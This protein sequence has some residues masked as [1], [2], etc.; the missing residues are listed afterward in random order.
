M[1]IRTDPL[2]PLLPFAS[3]SSSPLRIATWNCA[4]V[5]AGLAG[6]FTGLPV[7]PERFVV[8]PIARALAGFDLV[9]IQEAF[10]PIA[11]TFVEALGRALGMYCWLERSGES[12]TR[13]LPYGSGLAVLARRPIQVEFAPFHATPSGFD[14]WSNKGI[15]S[16]TV[17]VADRSGAEHAHRIHVVH[18][19]MQS[20]DPPLSPEVFRAIRA[21]Q[22]RELLTTLD[23]Q[24]R[25][26][27]LAARLVLGDFNI[28]AND[29][30]Y[31]SMLTP[32]M[33]ARRLVDAVTDDTLVTF[34]PTQNPMAAKYR[35]YER[36]V[37]VDHLWIGDGLQ[38]ALATHAPPR[39]I[40]H[41]AISLDARGRP[42][43]ASDHYGLALDLI[44]SPTRR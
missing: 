16:L 19:H 40:L 18:T 4:G 3:L 44:L 30:E 25:E 41:A 9:C 42:L 24:A 35:P 13:R 29:D 39:L 37:R 28:R 5:P 14:G 11:V 34:S 7:R 17:D 12:P 1:H 21:A 2:W 38:T 15:S 22:L 33:H 43:F 20:D 27:P 10:V 26:D 32:E 23:R 6:I 8:G 31:T 36:D